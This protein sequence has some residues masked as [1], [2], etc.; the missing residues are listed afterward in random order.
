[1]LLI[2]NHE[3]LV[4]SDDGHRLAGIYRLG[5]PFK[6]FIH[7]L[8][9][10]AGHVVSLASP[11]DHVHHKGLMYA[12]RVPGLNF[13]E[14]RSTLPGERVGR[15]AHLGFDA[16]VDRGPEAGFTQRL[17]WRPV[18]GGEPVLTEVRRVACRAGADGRSF[19]WTWET[20]L[21]AVA[22]TRLIRS[23]WSNVRKRDGV[24]VNYH[25]LGLRLRREFGGGTGNNALRLDSGEEHW[26]RGQPGY[27]F[28]E[29][30]G[31][32][33]RVVAFT[34]HVDGLHPPPRIRVTLTQAAGQGDALF[35]KE[36]PF[37]F[38]ALGPSNLAERELA[39]G[40]VVRGRYTVTVE[41][42]GVD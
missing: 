1:M 11:H 38:L 7:P 22:A 21:T 27:D 26:N 15:Q 28:N 37:A 6:P 36:V 19:V 32:T 17:A 33:P 4:F 29:A 16:W 9:S 18:G 12:L 40:E 10:P 25:G 20:D 31:A 42:V 39:G 13:W 34:G 24:K 14:E 41:D 2:H 35:V 23:Q 30:M 5:D 8:T 3:G